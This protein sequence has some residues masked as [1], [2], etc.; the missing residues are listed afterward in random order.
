M[1]QVGGV[2]YFKAQAKGAMEGQ[3]KALIGRRD[4]RLQGQGGVIN[5]AGNGGGTFVPGREE[6]AA[7]VEGM[8]VHGQGKNPGHGRVQGARIINA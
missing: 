8:F 1:A 6:H 4:W 2:F 5:P 7:D 3:Q